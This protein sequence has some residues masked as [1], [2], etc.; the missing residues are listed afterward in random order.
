MS[1][2]YESNHFASVHYESAHYGREIIAPP[3]DFTPEPTFPPGMGE[4]AEARWRRIQIED[5]L[6]MLVIQCWL[7]MKD[8]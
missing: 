4:D 8:R 2:H 6:I 3:P 5:E 1:A 7:T